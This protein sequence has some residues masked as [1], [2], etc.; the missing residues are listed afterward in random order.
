MGKNELEEI[1]QNYLRSKN[2]Q[3]EAKNKKDRCY[4][5]I[6]KLKDF[7]YIECHSSYFKGIGSCEAAEDFP[8]ECYESAPSYC[9]VLDDQGNIIIDLTRIAAGY[10][11]CSQMLDEENII[12]P[13][14]NDKA[15][16]SSFNIDYVNNYQ[17]FRIKDKTLQLINTLSGRP[18][19]SDALLRKKLLGL[20]NG[21]LYDFEKGITISNSSMDEFLTEEH[22]LVKLSRYWNLPCEDQQEF[23]HIIAERMERENLIGGYKK[24]EV[25]KGNFA[26]EYHT[27]T[28]IDKNGDIANDLLYYMDNYEL[29]SV[30]GE[31][32]IILQQLKENLISR[33]DEKIAA[34]E[35]RHK[36]IQQVKSKMMGKI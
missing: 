24:I 26:G 34:L 15:T 1:A 3:F 20:T 25:Q 32:D 19:V 23:V 13:I 36:A 29:I 21:Q 30:V 12:L 2:I 17:H 6:K 8:V 14:R 4:F 35:R 27:F 5:E 9:F 11:A 28:F 31:R 7:F 10:N 33:I 16:G 18:N 22:Q